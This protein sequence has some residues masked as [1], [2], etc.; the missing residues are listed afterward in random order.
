MLIGVLVKVCLPVVLGF[1]DSLQVGL[2]TSYSQSCIKVAWGEERGK[3]GI[4]IG[5]T[6]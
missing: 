6:P 3:G 1:I 5:H 4:A 2:P